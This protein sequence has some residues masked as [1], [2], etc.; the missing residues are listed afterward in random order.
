MIW[1][2]RSLSARSSSSI[3]LRVPGSSGRAGAGA[4]TNGLD[5][6]SQA[7][8]TVL[9]S[10]AALFYSARHGGYGGLARLVNAAPIQPFE[11]GGELGCREPHHPV[12][13]LRPA[14]L[15]L[16]QPLGD[17]NHAGAVPEHEFNPV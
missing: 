1:R 6:G 5:H 17:E 4:V 9:L 16:L 3:A 7:L 2:R 8:A 11:Q 15:A 10:C 14:E 13:D 12:L